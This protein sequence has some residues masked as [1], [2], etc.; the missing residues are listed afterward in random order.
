MSFAKMPLVLILTIFLA[1]LSFTAVLGKGPD[2]QPADSAAKEQPFTGSEKAIVNWPKAGNWIAGD[3]IPGPPRIEVFYPKGQSATNWTEMGTVEFDSK[4]KHIDLFGLAR[5]IF[6]GTQKGSPNA[7][8]NVLTDGFKDEKNKAYPFIF[9]RIDCPDF[10]SGEPGQ[11]QFWLLIQGKSGIFTVQ[12]SYKGTV[13][14]QGK[15]NEILQIM[16]DAQIEQEK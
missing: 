3:V 1:A 10:L 16:K 13:L 15:G 5:T 7:K 6:L 11:I 4:N 2:T 9:F 12:Y 8:W 14:P